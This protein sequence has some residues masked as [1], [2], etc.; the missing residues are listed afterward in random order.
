MRLHAPLLLLLSSTTAAQSTCGSLITYRQY[1]VLLSNAPPCFQNGCG[2]P[3]PARSMSAQWQTDQC[4][5]EC[6]SDLACRI[7]GWPVLNMTRTCTTVPEDWLFSSNNTG[8]CCASGSEPFALADWVG[9]LCNAPWN[10]TV[11]QHDATQGE[12]CPNSDQILTTF[13]LENVVTSFELVF[14]IAVFWFAAI[15]NRSRHYIRFFG[16]P[17]VNSWKRAVLL[18]IWYPLCHWLA[19]SFW[20]AALIR[21]EPGYQDVP[22]GLLALLLC[23]RPNS[24]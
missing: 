21:L 23:A 12:N 3:P 9:G 7:P 16:L 18:G 13:A 5:T 4:T 14:S 6:Q 17:A 20:S 10:W 22:V 8:A 24:L 1:S 19:S 15:T 11:R 2:G